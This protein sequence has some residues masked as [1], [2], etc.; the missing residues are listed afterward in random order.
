MILLN[1]AL[2]FVDR[3]STK[4]NHENS[5]KIG[6]NGPHLHV[7]GSLETLSGITKK[8]KYAKMFEMMKAEF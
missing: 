1:V 6:R 7:L 2:C 5:S 4:C 3:Y 8:K